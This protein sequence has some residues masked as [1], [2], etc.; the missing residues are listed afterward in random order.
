MTSLTSAQIAPNS[1]EPIAQNQNPINN[2]TS[3]FNM[4]GSS[5]SIKFL[6]DLFEAALNDGGF[7]TAPNLGN[8]YF[9]LRQLKGFLQ[10]AELKNKF[11]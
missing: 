7:A 1:V 8:Y 3:Y 6:D 5:D 10:Q 4:F 9:H 11:S 2:Y